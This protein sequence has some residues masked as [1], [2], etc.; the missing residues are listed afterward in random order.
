MN[1]LR[2]FAG[3]AAGFREIIRAPR[4]HDAETVIR[5]QLSRRHEHFLELMRRVV[6][7]NAAHPYRQ[8][9]EIAGCGYEDL[10]AG[11]RRDGLDTTLARLHRSG[12]YLTHDEFKLKRPIVRGNRTIAADAGSFQNP[13]ATGRM[14]GFSGGSRSAGTQVRVS[15]TARLH[16]EA[17][18]KL[19]FDE[20]DATRRRYV[21]L[22]PTLPAVDGLMN[23]AR[24]TRLGCTLDRWFSPVVASADSLHYRMATYGLLAMA[25]LHGM[26]LPFPE[27]LLSNDYSPVARVIDERR[28]HG[29]SVLVRTYT[30]GAVRVAAAAREMGVSIEGTLFIV[31]GETLTEAKRAT[32]EAAGA[33][34]FPHYAISELGSIGY[35]CRQLT[36]GNA[37][38]L[39]ADSLAVL[40]HRREAPLSGEQ[41]DSLLFT[42]LQLDAPFVL[43]NAETDD[44]GTLHRATCDCRF[45]R[46]GFTT[47]IRDIASFG[48]LTGHGVTLVGTDVVRILEGA[49]P[50]R[51]GGSA[52]DYQLVEHD[53]AGQARMT[54]RVSRRVPI[55]ALSDVKEHFLAQLRAFQGGQIASRMWQHAD[56]LDV[57]HED[58]IMSGHR[59]KILPLHVL[60]SGVTSE[61]ARES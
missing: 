21:L 38:H 26:R 2:Y 34:I 46:L 18:D 53:G 30:S 57:V 7:A 49:L 23:L 6:F 56:A 35:A 58:P 10:A 51:F 17:Y 3:A 22:K 52:T 60:G 9:F 41:V 29:L 16:R 8:M 11:V 61:L 24:G 36:T 19:A 28:R 31:G 15:T 14:V 4:L 27:H 42:A 45:A 5:A 59:G 13:L 33:Q 40:S 55:A 20:F 25:R 50:Q 12:V 32:I 54:L 48:K 47:V 1:R 44:S 37:V 39:N 43:V